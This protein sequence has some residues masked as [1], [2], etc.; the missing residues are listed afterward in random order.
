MLGHPKDIS[1]LNGDDYKYEDVIFSWRE[2]P[3]KDGQ[4]YK[5]LSQKR[6]GFSIILFSH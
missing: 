5:Y 6:N 1:V 4:N 3:D 2:G